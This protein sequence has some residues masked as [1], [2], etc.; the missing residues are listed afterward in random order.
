MNRTRLRAAIA[1]AAL[2][3][4]SCGG[5]GQGGPSS[6]APPVD[7]TTWPPAD[8]AV[9]PNFHEELCPDLRPDGT[10]LALRLL[11]PDQY[12]AESIRSS[13]GCTFAAG[14]DRGLAVSLAVEQSLETFKEDS[15]DPDDGGGGDDGTSNIE[16][17]PDETVLGDRRG[18][19]LTWDSYNDGL[20][21]DHRVVQTDGVRLTWYTPQGQ[22]D[23]WTSLLESVMASVSVVESGRATC[24]R[25]RTTAYYE[26][27]VPQT[28]SIDS[29]GEACRLYFR[30]RDSL[31]RYGE[32]LIR[33]RTPLSRLATSLE[34][35]KNV[36]SVD[37][38][39]DAAT[40]AGETADR[41]TWVVAQ[42]G[43]TW[44]LVAIGRDDVQ[45]TWGA[46]PEQWQVEQDDY[47]RFIGSVRLETR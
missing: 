3:L 42:P 26:P 23:Q 29:Y 6:T 24:H 34:A 32:V 38:E 27:P 21:L 12:A 15:V 1:A 47:R 22:S 30:P 40:L 14:I 18:E 41:L 8:D 5:Q 44:R 39:P 17:S 2:L 35:R 19:L 20:P 16:Y 13:T 36:T 28:D 43:G 9:P 46:T 4:T 11:V 31:L 37:L 10:G 25:G 33:P 7:Q 45:V